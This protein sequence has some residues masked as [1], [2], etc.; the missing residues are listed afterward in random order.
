MKF[1]VDVQLPPLLK[2]WFLGKGAKEVIHVSELDGGLRM[3]DSKVW[4]TAEE[5]GQIIVTKDTQETMEV[6]QR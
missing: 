6:H 3:S 2:K 4:E 1:L 5:K